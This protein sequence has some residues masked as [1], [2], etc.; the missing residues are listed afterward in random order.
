[1]IL[2]LRKAC[3]EVIE[4][5]QNK[6]AQIDEKHQELLP[7][8]VNRIFLSVANDIILLKDNFTLIMTKVTRL[9][10]KVH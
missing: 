8:K 10:T 3:I 5:I 7:K 2:E 4:R 9:E 6:F 1:M